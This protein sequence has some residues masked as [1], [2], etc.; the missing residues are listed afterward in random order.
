MYPGDIYYSVNKQVPVN[1]ISNDEMNTGFLLLLEVKSSGRPGELYV[2]YSSTDQD[3]AASAIA[4]AKGPIPTFPNAPAPFTLAKLSPT[5]LELGALH[6]TSRTGPI[7]DKKIDLVP[8]SD[9]MLEIA[10]TGIKENWTP[11]N[12]P[13]PLFPRDLKE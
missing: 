6:V 13:I 10:E 9:S 8:V 2:S 7:I 11:N 4:G 3:P 12:P 5:D 1:Q